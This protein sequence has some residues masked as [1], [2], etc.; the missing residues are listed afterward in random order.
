MIFAIV[1]TLALTFGFILFTL[2]SRLP[3]YT[4]AIQDGVIDLTGV[5]FDNAVAKLPLAWDYYPG[6][7]YA[8]DDFIEGHTIAPRRFMPEDE[9]AY[10]TG[11]YRAM[12]KVIPDKTYAINAWSLDYATRIFIDGAEIMNVGTVSGNAEGF[13]PQV[14]NYILPLTPRD[15][16]IEVIIQYAN[17]S[18]HEG[19]AMRAITFGLSDNIISY[20][21]GS[22]NSA[23]LL[24]GALLLVAAFYFMLFVGGRG[25]QN[26]TFSLCC[27]FLATRSQQFVLSL[28]PPDYSWNLIYRFVYI[29][30]ICTGLAFLLLVYSMHPSLL[31]RKTVRVMVSGTAAVTLGLALAAMFVPLNT[32]AR[33]VAPSYFV[34]IPAI[35]CICWTFG[36]LFIKGR[37]IDRITAVGIAALFVTLFAEMVLQRS[38]PEITRSGLAP[39]GMLTFAICQM[40]ALGMENAELERLNRMKTVFLQNMS[41]EMKTPLTVISTHVLN[42]ADQLDFEMDKEDMRNSLNRA[43]QEIMRLGRMVGQAVEFPAVAE[44]TVQ[45]MEPLDI[46]P[47]LRAGAEIYRPILEK[48]GNKLSLNLPE[49]L[50]KIYGNAD[51]LLQTLSNLLSNAAR[52]TE[53]GEITIQASVIENEKALN[54]NDSPLNSQFIKV[55]VRDSGEGVKPELLPF[56]FKRGV[57]ANG[58]GFGL[59]ICKNVI[60]TH[61]GEIR[62]D[63]DYGK[64]TTVT[65]ILPTHESKTGGK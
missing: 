59:P 55:T 19:G 39:F 33:M 21:Q 24:G 34:F 42:A 28:M 56:L 53:N 5:D 4:A 6:E 26:L 27:F 3:E 25:F 16:N 40:L 17:F 61:G 20:A 48:R 1:L 9:Q 46:T 50:P 12:L 63:S 8:P 29:N 64:G 7:L 51:M 41:H 49:S 30:N 11:T 23:L 47:I 45:H 57:S 43:Q 38:I 54:Q 44:I 18:H 65:F 22:Q 2:Q 58:T 37:S 35:A 60:D 62:L 13:I 14:K 15:E 10:R 31:P 52:H 36:K 32:V